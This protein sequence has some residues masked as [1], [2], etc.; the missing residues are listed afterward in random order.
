LAIANPTHATQWE[1]LA[2]DP[3]AGWSVVTG[4]RKG[5]AKKGGAVAGGD[6][7]S[8]GEEAGGEG[9]GGGTP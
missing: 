3:D 4:K 5:K 1:T 7:G 8:E 2:E 9:S 6:G